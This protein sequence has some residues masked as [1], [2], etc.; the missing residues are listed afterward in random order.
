MDGFQLRGTD[1]PALIHT[2]SN[3]QMPA[4]ASTAAAPR[5]PP[6]KMAVGEDQAKE[7]NRMGKAMPAPTASPQNLVRK[8]PRTMESIPSFVSWLM[9]GITESTSV[10]DRPSTRKNQ[11]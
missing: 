2:S 7:I 1:C 6:D 4:R 9:C 10:I 5:I 8:C 3:H 11:R